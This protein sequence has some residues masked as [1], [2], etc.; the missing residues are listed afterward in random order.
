MNPKDPGSEG[1]CRKTVGTC[2][3][4]AAQTW[5]MAGE[6]WPVEGNGEGW[7]QG[8]QGKSR[9]GAED[10]VAPCSPGQMLCG[11]LLSQ[12]VWL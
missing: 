12:A 8:S 5:V 3:A 6:H 7:G 11:Q 2:L 10:S 1:L 4:G 9:E